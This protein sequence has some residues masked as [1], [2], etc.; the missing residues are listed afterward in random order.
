MAEVSNVY[1]RLVGTVVID[2][3]YALRGLVGSGGMAD[4]FL[5]RDKVL[6]RDF[7]STLPTSGLKALRRPQDAQAHGRLSSDSSLDVTGVL[8]DGFVPKTNTSVQL[9]KHRILGV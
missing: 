1:D 7:E 2:N 6:D 5:A 9:P 4:V 3:R 8:G